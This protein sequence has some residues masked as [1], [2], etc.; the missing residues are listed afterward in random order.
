MN[1]YVALLFFIIAII[2]WCGVPILSLPGHALGFILVG[3]G[4]GL[5]FLANWCIRAGAWCMGV[6]VEEDKD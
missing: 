1:G 5:N 6:P 4:Y 2:G 3:A